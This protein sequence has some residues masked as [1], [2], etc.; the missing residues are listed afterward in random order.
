M[1]ELFQQLLHWVNANPGWAGA[2]VFLMA[3]A[4]SLAIV[5]MAVP[6]VAV[7][8]TV[9][10]LIGAGAL[11][12]WPMVAWAVAGA[13]LGD[14]IS[15]WLGRRYQ[16]QLTR[17]WPFSR[18]PETLERGIAFFHKYGGKS[19]VIGRFFGPVRAVIPLV[20]GMMEMPPN[21]FLFA[22]VLSALGWAPAYLLP[23]MVFG[24]SLELASEV[25]LR[26]VLLLVVLVASLWFLGWLSHRLF[27]RMQPWGKELVQKV[28]ALGERHPGLRQIAGALGDLDHPESRGLAMLAGLLV[29]TSSALILVALIPDRSLLIADSALHLGLDQLESSAGTH[30]MLAISSMAGTAATLAMSLTLWLLFTGFGLKQAG[31]HWIGGTFFIW[32]LSLGLEYFLRRNLSLLGVFPDIYVLRATVFFGLAAVL[33]ATPVVHP[34]RWLVY[35]AATILIMA[36]LL[37]QLYLGSTLPAVLHALGGGL[38]WVTAVG[39]AYRTHSRGETLQPKHALTIAATVL[40]LAAAT[41]LTTPAPPPHATAVQVQGVL[42]EKAWW[43]EAWQR[44]P[45][46][47]SDVLDAS[48]YPLNLQYAGKVEQLEAALESAGWKKVTPARGVEWLKLLATS[49]PMQ[50]LPVLPHSHNGKLASR[51]LVRNLGDKR[52]ALY[53]WPS[54]YYLEEDGSPIWLGKVTLQQKRQWLALFVFPYSTPDKAQALEVLTRDLA[55]SGLLQKRADEGQ[56]LLLRGTAKGAQP[57]SLSGSTPGKLAPTS[58]FRGAEVVTE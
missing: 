42:S 54:G 9:G 11:D 56:L 24:A 5:G 53:L 49:T 33:A 39:M 32:L 4:E 25:A 12:F 21:R 50:E 31:R 2:V 6:G 14:G 36:V 37:A 18:H 38:I 13:I 17:L 44:L 45:R 52:V 7:L 27:L 48:H 15:F 10:A 20:A 23:G 29:L 22:N 35:S 41:A 26:L 46:H 3:F 57:L 19:V 43:Q 34:H 55:G 51:T 8:F 30:L 47:R 58:H 16:Q 28:L 40:L 1:A